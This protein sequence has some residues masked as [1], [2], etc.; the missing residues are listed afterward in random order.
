MRKPRFTYK[1]AF[2]HVMSKG[3]KGHFI[4]S[5]PS[6]KDN[7]LKLIN[8]EKDK[9]RIGIFAYCIYRNYRRKK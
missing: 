5:Y 2:H 8:E 4:F 3:Y 6:Y 1:E 7:L 9:K